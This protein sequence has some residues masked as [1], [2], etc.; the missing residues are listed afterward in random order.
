MDVLSFN[1]AGIHRD[2][3]GGPTVFLYPEETKPTR[4]P[5]LSPLSGG[6]G[7]AIQ[8]LSQPVTRIAIPLE[9]KI[10]IFRSDGMMFDFALVLDGQSRRNPAK[11]RMRIPFD[12]LIF[13]IQR[14]DAGRQSMDET[15]QLEGRDE[16]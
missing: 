8:C 5:L 2:F 12:H 13:R 7:R 9:R 11:D 1:S 6:S 16:S 15:R 14:I 4:Q 3:E 10:Q